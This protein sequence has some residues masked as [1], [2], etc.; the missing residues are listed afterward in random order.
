[1][2]TRACYTPTGTNDPTFIT[3]IE[4]ALAVVDDDELAV[5]SRLHSG[6]CVAVLVTNGERPRGAGSTRA[7]G[8]ARG[9]I[10]CPARKR[11]RRARKTATSSGRRTHQI[12]PR[13]RPLGAR[14]PAPRG[15]RVGDQ[16]RDTHAAVQTAADRELVVVDDRQSF[17]DVGDE[18]RVV[19]PGRRVAGTRRHPR[20]RSRG[21]IRGG[22][23]NRIA[24][25]REELRVALEDEQRHRLLREQAH[26]ELDVMIRDL[27]ESGKGAGGQIE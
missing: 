14:A 11:C 25:D 20:A 26:F 8:R 16:D 6:M 3:D 10:W 24:R 21:S 7:S 18:G 4:E 9:P 27:A 1:V 17:F 2:A 19:G 15:A 12:G 5:R 23:P 22:Q 13:A